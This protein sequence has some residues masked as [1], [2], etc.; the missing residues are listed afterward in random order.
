MN[1]K[2]ILVVDD[3]PVV[4]KAVEGKL[5]S[6]GYEVITAEDA[7]SA[8]SNV[9]LGRPDLVLLDIAFPPDVA[10]G[11]VVAWDGLLIINWLRRMEEAHDVPIVILSGLEAS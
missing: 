11:G 8:V 4:V 9:R 3:N 5:Q 7:A 6:C 1:P 10:H 2:K